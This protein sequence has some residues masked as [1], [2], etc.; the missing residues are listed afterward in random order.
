ML[1]PAPERRK[2]E[3]GACCRARVC[4]ALQTE[5]RS[6]ASTW[7]T[8]RDITRTIYGRRSVKPSLAVTE[9]GSALPVARGV[10]LRGPFLRSPIARSRLSLTRL[11]WGDVFG[12]LGRAHRHPPDRAGDQIGDLLRVR[13]GTGAPR[14]PKIAST[15]PSHPCSER[16]AGRAAFPGC[17]ARCLRPAWLSSADFARVAS[18]VSACLASRAP[19]SIAL[20][21]TAIGMTQA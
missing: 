18:L 7:K 4:G 21:C 19:P 8:G 2:S 9:S 11:Y 14:V 12:S 10:E 1:G 5:A 6:R 16:S 20:D 17:S 13:T 15:D 3:D